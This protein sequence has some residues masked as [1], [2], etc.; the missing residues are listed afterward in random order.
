MR[1][2]C[3]IKNKLLPHLISFYLNFFIQFSS[4]YRG[5][6]YISFFLVG[7]VVCVC[8]PADQEHIVFIS[9]ENAIRVGQAN[10]CCK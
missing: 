7:D 2:I 1:F 4:L 5:F 8:V 10:V 9:S 3:A 6:R